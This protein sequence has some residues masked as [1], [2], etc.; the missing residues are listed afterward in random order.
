MKIQ[1]LEVREIWAML[2]CT[3]TTRGSGKSAPPTKI[4]R[5]WHISEVGLEVYEEEQKNSV[6]QLA[7]MQVRLRD[8]PESPKISRAQTHTVPHRVRGNLPF[9]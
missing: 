8:P 2:G 9:S 1:T 4:L 5:K 6:T 7:M 3:H